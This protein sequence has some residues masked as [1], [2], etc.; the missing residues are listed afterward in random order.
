MESR[1]VQ[2]RWLKTQATDVSGALQSGA[3]A[4]ASTAHDALLRRSPTWHLVLTSH[5]RSTWQ[6]AVTWLTLWVTPPR[7][8]PAPAHARHRPQRHQTGPCAVCKLH[9]LNVRSREM[10]FQAFQSFSLSNIASVLRVE[11]VNIYSFRIVFSNL[12]CC[13]K[14][15]HHSRDV[16]YFSNIMLWYKWNQMMYSFHIYYMNSL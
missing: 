8:Y 4:S 3:P 7:T 13:L 6:R 15:I 12:C 1:K 10:R 11:D 16:K 14:V 5:S 9:E 2:A